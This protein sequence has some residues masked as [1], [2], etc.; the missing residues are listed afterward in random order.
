MASGMMLTRPRRF[1]GRVFLSK[2]PYPMLCRSPYRPSG[3]S[4]ALAKCFGKRLWGELPKPHKGFTL[5]PACQRNQTERSAARLIALRAVRSLRQYAAVSCFGAPPVGFIVRP[6][7][8]VP[9]PRETSH[10]RVAFDY[11]QAA[12]DRLLASGA[13]NP[14]RVSPLTQFLCGGSLSTAFQASSPVGAT[15]APFQSSASMVISSA[16]SAPAAKR[17]SRS[18][19]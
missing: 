1:R 3:C 7:T 8:A 5:D 19:R 16:C 17:S 10:L 11:A 13:P 2:N 12:T 9:S 15:S 18:F 14:A 4:P 6:G